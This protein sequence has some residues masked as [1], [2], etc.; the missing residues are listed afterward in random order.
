MGHLA[1]LVEKKRVG[2]K[3]IETIY[4]LFFKEIEKSTCVNKK[5][6]TDLYYHASGMK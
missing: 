1:S 2:E 5:E 6:E 4:L 3:S